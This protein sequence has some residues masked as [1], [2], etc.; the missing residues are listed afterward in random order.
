[1]NLEASLKN[2]RQKDGQ[3]NAASRHL[4]KKPKRNMQL[5]LKSFLET[6]LSPVLK[7]MAAWQSVL[8]RFMVQELRG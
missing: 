5:D 7:M 6:C 3:T 4:H 1:M 8:K 2:P